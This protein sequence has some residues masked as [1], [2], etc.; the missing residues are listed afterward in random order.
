[1]K[2]CFR[3]ALTEA[4]NLHI[5]RAY[6]HR[7]DIGYSKNTLLCPKQNQE[8]SNDANETDYATLQ[9]GEYFN[10]EMMKIKR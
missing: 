3:I 2:A 9:V 7:S 8:H 1:L 4:D 5:P 10:K 6:F